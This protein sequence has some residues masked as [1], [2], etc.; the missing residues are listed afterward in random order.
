MEEAARFYRDAVRVKPDSPEAHNNLA[1]AL[2]QSGKM[3][4]SIPHFEQAVRAAPN[5]VSAR[6]N[7][8]GVL[9]RMGRVEEAKAQ[10]E[11]AL[12]IMPDYAPARQNLA[13]IQRLEA[14]APPRGKVVAPRRA[15]GPDLSRPP[16]SL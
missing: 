6:V 16:P 13:V 8:G 1:S 2:A 3:A 14:Q 15:A 7:F 11:A 10:F 5:Y 12:R 4:E 9:F